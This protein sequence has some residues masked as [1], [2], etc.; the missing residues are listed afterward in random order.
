MARFGGLMCL[1]MHYMYMCV[2]VHAINFYIQV[3]VMFRVR[4]GLFS[5]YSRPPDKIVQL[6][7]FS[8]FSA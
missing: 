7:M 5:V 4:F 3:T 2:K 8:Y 1:N 6:E